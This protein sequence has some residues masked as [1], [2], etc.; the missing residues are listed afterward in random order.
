M[1]KF[2]IKNYRPDNSNKSTYIDALKIYI[3]HI[4]YKYS[5]LNCIFQPM[6]EI[7][8]DYSRD[9]RL[10]AAVNVLFKN[11]GP[12]IGHRSLWLLRHATYNVDKLAKLVYEEEIRLR[13][14]VWCINSWGDPYRSKKIN[15]D[16]SEKMF[17]EEF[18]KK[19]YD[20]TKEILLSDK[21]CPGEKTITILNSMYELG[22]K[23][24]N[25]GY[26]KSMLDERYK[27][28]DGVVEAYCKM[29]AELAKLKKLID[30]N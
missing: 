29:E 23:T 30:K 16:M 19:Y 9:I 22:I 3:E 21:T 17:R 27:I 2:K 11:Y 12:K 24:F 4:I 28:N 14:L 18:I 5:K 13:S 25:Q 1:N 7:V 6:T 20:V 26:E 10:R 8:G 15:Y